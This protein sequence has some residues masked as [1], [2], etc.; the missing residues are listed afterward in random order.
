MKKKQYARVSHAFLYHVVSAATGKTKVMKKK[1]K[2]VL[3]TKPVIITLTEDHVRRSIEL[4]GAGRTDLCS[5][6]ICALDHAKAFPHK[7]EGH[8]DFEYSRIYVVS[9]LDELSLPAEC[10]VYE[11]NAGELAKLNDSPN[12][13][14]EKLL[15]FVKEKGPIV[16]KLTPYRQ[17]SEL[18]RPGKE[19]K[20]TGKR[21]KQP[22]GAKLRYAVLQL[23]GFPEP[24]AV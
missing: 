2:T 5:G 24:V 6:A 21:E 23:G 16:I 17:R 12:G 14:Q 10:Y 3:P 7:V 15:E 22:R 11:H 18:G 20:P 8:V 9:S 19:R 4:H 1:A 13:G